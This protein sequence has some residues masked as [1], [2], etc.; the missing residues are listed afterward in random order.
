MKKIEDRRQIKE[1]QDRGQ[2]VFLSPKTRKLSDDEAVKRANQSSEWGE[3]LV[4]VGFI[5][6]I[7]WACMS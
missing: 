1:I 3:V 4:I 2:R 5:F 6:A 7:L